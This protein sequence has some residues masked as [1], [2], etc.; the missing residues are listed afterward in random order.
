MSFYFIGTDM[1]NVAAALKEEIIRLARKEFRIQS[2]GMKKA[3]AHYR[4]DIAALKRKV[5]E[6][7]HQTVRGNETIAQDATVSRD[8]GA[9]TRSRFTA[10]GLRAERKRLGLSAGD[11]AKLV[12]VS[13][14]SIYKWEGEGTRP[15]TKHLAKMESLR[16]MGRKEAKARLQKTTQPS[17]QAGST[18]LVV[19]AGNG[20]RAC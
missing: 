11:Y 17:R 5:T 14:Q 8:G 20:Q 3:S 7:Q 2:R 16:G 15:R 18:Q 9:T 12:G 6:L 1:A 4:R 13:A 19:A 10:R